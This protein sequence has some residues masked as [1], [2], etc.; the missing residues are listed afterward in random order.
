[1]KAGCVSTEPSPPLWLLAELTYACPLQCPYCSNPVDFA[2][3]GPELDTQEWLSVLREARA[4][5]AVQLGFSG[6]EPLL[7]PDLEVLIAE[8]HRL[9]YYTNLITSGLRLDAARVERLREAGLDHIQLSFQASARELNDRMAG[10]ASFEQK[11]AAARLVKAAGYPMVLCFVLY[12]DNID[13]VPQMLAL[14]EELGADY[15]ELANT[16][17]HGWALLNRER[18]MPSAEQVKTAERAT[19]QYRAQ[20]DGRMKVYYVVPD[21]HDG[22]PKACVNGWGSTFLT[23]TADGKALPCHS[24]RD[25]PGLSFPDVRRQPLREIWY[26]SPLFNRFRGFDWM[27]EPC[28]SC[29][30]RERDFGGCRCQAYLLTGDAANADPACSQSPLHAAVRNAVAG[31]GESVSSQTLIFR[32]RRNSLTDAKPEP[33][34]RKAQTWTP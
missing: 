17:Y 2:H 7:R 21:Y 29:P 1:M 12:R 27:K 10:T 33:A 34:P 14:A 11:K 6:G 30:E 20:S 3:F 24:A 16:Q 31:A 25:L 5:G 19:N 23:V 32:N 15:V 9:G 18:L 13:C 8:A 22:R 28:R 26:D 4:L